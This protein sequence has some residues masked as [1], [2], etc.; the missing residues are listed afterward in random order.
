[1]MG[2]ITICPSCGS[3]AIK[4]IRRNW[5][6]KVKGQTYVVP[7]LEYYLCPQCGE[8]VY[9]RQAMR[10]IEAHSPAFAKRRS[11]KKSA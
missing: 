4:K 10:K 9:D 5:T 7:N 11:E 6:G 3:R 2:F 8:T 1:M